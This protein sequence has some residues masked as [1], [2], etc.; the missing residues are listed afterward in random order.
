MR[1]VNEISLFE[2][3]KGLL[4]DLENTD[5]GHRARNVQQRINPAKP[6]ERRFHDS[7]CG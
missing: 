4:N 1:R 7:V 5:T 2:N 3:I 6:I